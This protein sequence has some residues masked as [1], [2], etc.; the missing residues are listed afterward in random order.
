MRS[1]APCGI[2]DSLFDTRV[3]NCHILKKLL[4]SRNILV[5]LILWQNRRFRNMP[6]P[7]ELGNNNCDANSLPLFLGPCDSGEPN[8]EEIADEEAATTSADKAPVVEN[9]P[10]SSDAPAEDKEMKEVEEAKPSSGSEEAKGGSGA[11]VCV[12]QSSSSAATV[13]LSSSTAASE[14]QQEEP[15]PMEEGMR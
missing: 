11:A 14:E 1:R 13:T 5:I 2:D 4:I 9:Q 15:T 10:S 7:L 3:L 6:S 8:A 12:S